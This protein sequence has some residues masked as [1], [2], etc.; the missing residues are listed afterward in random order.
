MD[1]F[2]VN[3]FLEFS[4][5]TP[6][7]IFVI[8]K[9]LVSGEDKAIGG[10][11][12]TMDT[13]VS[14]VAHVYA[15]DI[16][17]DFI[18]KGILPVG[19]DY[20]FQNIKFSSG[21]TDG[22]KVIAIQK[23]VEKL[24]PTLQEY[25]R[26]NEEETFQDVTNQEIMD[27]LEKLISNASARDLTKNLCFKNNSFVQTPVTNTMKVSRST[28]VTAVTIKKGKSSTSCSK[29]APID[30]TGSTSDDEEEVDND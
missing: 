5:T 1:E 11:S 23:L 7:E 25:F 9:L 14:T 20:P 19:K 21:L 8:P 16:C 3:Q 22:E 12:I 29:E 26:P 10:T 18:K 15:A 28:V 2:N 30:F 27:Q 17:N 24:T 13:R 6:E 4:Y